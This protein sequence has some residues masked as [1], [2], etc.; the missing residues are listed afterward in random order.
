MAADGSENF[1]NPFT[2]F[3]SVYQATTAVTSTVTTTTTSTMTSLTST[4]LSTGTSQTSSTSTA[5]TT[6][7]STTTSLSS[8]TQTSS[9]TTTFIYPSLFVNPSAGLIGSTVGV[10]GSGFSTSD[11]SCSISG[12][13]VA[14]STC[15][16]SGGALT[17]TFTVVTV[18]IGSY[19]V[20]ATGNQAGDSA[21]A[22]FTVP[23]TTGPAIPGFPV[24][25]IL[26]GLLLGT[27]I[28]A[29]LRRRPILNRSSIV[30]HDVCMNI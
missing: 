11:T 26:A 19:S 27:I 14:S 10:S 3:A 24:E 21:A 1:L 20:T 15:S 25:A 9:A 18:G 16:I 17:G 29:L 30:H 7:T 4:T 23:T 22:T 13:V 6:T 2:G 5:T 8:T 28:I 12:M